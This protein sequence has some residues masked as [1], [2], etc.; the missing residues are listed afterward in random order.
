M[1]CLSY[2]RQ[3]PNAVQIVLCA[4]DIAFYRNS[5]WHIGN[6]VPYVKRATLHDGFYGEEDRTGS[7]MPLPIEKQPKPP[8]RSPR[9]SRLA[10]AHIWLSGFVSIIL[11]F[12]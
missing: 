1:T 6:Y 11:R 9:N 10:W 3:M 4:G 2:T 5:S 7:Q 8:R 12:E